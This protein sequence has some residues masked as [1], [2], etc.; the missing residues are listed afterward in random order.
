LLG[1][2]LEVVVCLPQAIRI[3]CPGWISVLP[4][5]L[6]LADVPPPI[7]ITASF[8]SSVTLRANCDVSRHHAVKRRVASPTQPL[9]SRFSEQLEL[10]RVGCRYTINIIMGE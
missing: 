9:G 8:L 3:R 2:F 1:S 10:D 4:T 5:W 6:L 7:G